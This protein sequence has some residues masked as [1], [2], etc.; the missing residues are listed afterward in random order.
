MLVLSCEREVNQ[1]LK[2]KST[3]CSSPRDQTRESTSDQL[4]SLPSPPPGRSLRRV[5]RVLKKWLG[6]YSLWTVIKSDLVVKH[7]FTVEINRQGPDREKNM[8]T[9]REQSEKMASNLE[10]KSQCGMAKRN[11][12]MRFEVHI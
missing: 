2:A 8:R 5:E 7:M 6:K 10:N 1:K 11:V 4:H 9:R 12:E 3:G